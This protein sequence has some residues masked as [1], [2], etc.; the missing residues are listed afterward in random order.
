MSERTAGT[1]DV[2]AAN[3]EYIRTLPADGPRILAA[4]GPGGLM[5]YIES[6]GMDVQTVRVIRILSPDRRWAGPQ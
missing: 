3:G 6:G 4:F 1:T 5:A 2:V